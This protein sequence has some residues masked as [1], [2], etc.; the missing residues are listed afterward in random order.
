MRE[1]A[2]FEYFKAKGTNPLEQD[3]TFAELWKTVN[4]NNGLENCVSS[5][6]EG[7]KKVRASPACILESRLKLLPDGGGNIKSSSSFSARF[8]LRNP[9]PTV[10]SQKRQKSV[11]MEILNTVS[12]F[13]FHFHFHFRFPK[14]C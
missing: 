8:Q 1:S 5:P 9:A 14:R 7:I 4:K 3:S 6:S 2:V 13:L 12:L 11:L 10:G